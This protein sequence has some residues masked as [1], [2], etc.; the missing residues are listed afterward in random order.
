MHDERFPKWRSWVALALLLA[1][2]AVIALGWP[3]AEKEAPAPVVL[4]REPTP[5]APP[6]PLK[7]LDRSALIEAA[8]KAASAYAAG[9][10]IDGTANELAGRRFELIMP[11]GCAGPSPAEAPI[12]NGW[13][14]DAESGILQVAFPSNIQGIPENF[15]RDSSEEATKVELG[16]GFWIEREWL[17]DAVCP[18]IVTNPTAN[19]VADA[20]SLAI[21][22]IGE[23]EE[24]RAKARDGADYRVSKRVPVEEAPDQQGLRISISGRLAADRPVPIQC[25][26]TQR[27]RRP[28]CIIL[29]RFDRIALTNATGS[30]IYGEWQN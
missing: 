2:A 23:A 26:S 9:S 4:T 11:L 5:L 15:F 20:P 14:Y 17:R 10:P 3:R 30:E 24:P 7:I 27:D 1:V 19:M 28:I 8:A 18:A 12:E 25:Q 22:E 13:R 21:A 29:A 16:K 6:P